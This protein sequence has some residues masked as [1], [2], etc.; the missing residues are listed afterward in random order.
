M[1]WT[2][3]TTAEYP[4]EGNLGLLD[5]QFLFTRLV[6]VLIMEIHRRGYECT[7][8]DAYRDPRVHG[9]VGQRVGYG[10]AYSNHKARLAIDLNLFLDGEYLTTTED[11]EPFGIFW[12][13]LHPLT[14][15]GGR[16]DDG[17]HYS[18][19]WQGRH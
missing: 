4:M 8:G 11:H 10:K 3:M 7:F 9:G 16:F 5:R 6:P 2:H 19:E 14:A 13:G 15:W 18:I 1:A 12:E 17:N